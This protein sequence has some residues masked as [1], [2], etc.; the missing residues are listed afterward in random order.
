MR[1]EIREVAFT[2]RRGAYG[3]NFPDS[4]LDDWL[5]AY[6]GGNGE[7]LRAVK[8]T[9]DPDSVF[10]FAQSIPGHVRDTSPPHPGLSHDRVK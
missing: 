9:Y 3:A 1:G 10:R 7:R 5:T 2:P 4:A 8:T 6:Y